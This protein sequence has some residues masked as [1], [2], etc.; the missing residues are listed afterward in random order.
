MAVERK[1]DG[2]IEEGMIFT[3]PD[4]DGEL[5]YRRLKVIGA[6]A[7][8][9]MLVL[10]EMPGRIRYAPTG[11]VFK[12]PELNLRI[13]FFLEE[14]PHIKRPDEVAPLGAETYECREHGQT[15][16]AH[17]CAACRAAAAAVERPPICA[18]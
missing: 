11:S 6:D 2:P 12:C 9:G 13:V 10:K 14:P 17:Y 15:I 7:D 8:D 1:Y 3:S 18:A 16:G 4:N 5:G